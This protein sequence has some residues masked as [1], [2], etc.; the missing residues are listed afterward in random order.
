MHA[1]AEKRARKALA[2][3]GLK[4]VE[5]IT[6]VTLR[7]PKNVL[8][9]ISNPDVYRAPNTNNWIV[10]G[11]AKVEDLNQQAQLQA[12]QQMAQQEQAE[13]AAQA[14]A[15]GVDPAD[16]LEGGKG[17]EKA[18]SKEDEEDDANVDISDLEDK[19][20]LPYSFLRRSSGGGCAAGLLTSRL[21]CQPRH[22]PGG[23][24]KGKGGQG[25][26]GERQR[27]CELDHE[28]DLGGAGPEPGRRPMIFLRCI[29][30]GMWQGMTLQRLPCNKKYNHHLML[31][32]RFVLL[33]RRVMP[34][35][36]D[37]WAGH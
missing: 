2:K 14:A 35:P 27:H 7:R 4:Q 17:K 24:V 30:C 34:L 26:A 13:A 25:A 36:P 12:A 16:V 28:L 3:L 20:S 1:R 18:E 8:L 31:L 33:V 15:G 11:E 21:G 22:E 23:R 37:P 10:F 29:E 9:V 6:R 32:A 19:V 5:G